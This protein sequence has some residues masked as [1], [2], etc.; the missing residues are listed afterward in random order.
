[1]RFML[2]TDTCIYIINQRPQKVIQALISQGTDNVVIS[3][4]TLAELEYGVAKSQHV[5]QNHNA[6]LKFLTPIAVVPFDD[7]AAYQYGYIRA[8]L[9]G[10]GMVIG[11]Y[12]MLIA[13]HALSRG[14]T[15]VTNN[16]QEFARVPG[17]SL[18]N[19]RHAT[20]GP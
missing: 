12:D 11:P 2:D 14:L 9:E 19:W 18:V 13:A 4:I 7:S 8:Y 1:M 6:L 10:R 20:P 15:L 16:T 5:S 3:A 17:L